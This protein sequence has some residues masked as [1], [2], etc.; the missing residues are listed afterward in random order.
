M[1]FVQNG[2]QRLTE[3]WFPDPVYGGDGLGG[4]GGRR[5]YVGTKTGR[6]YVL[7]GRGSASELS[8]FGVNDLPGLIGLLSGG[9]VSWLLGQAKNNDNIY[10]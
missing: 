4:G 7:G 2:D 8:D 10:R 5:D 1:L 9:P 3:N 6:A